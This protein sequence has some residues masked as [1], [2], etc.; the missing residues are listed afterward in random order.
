LRK[1][2]FKWEKSN[3]GPKK[4]KKGKFVVVA[5]SLNASKCTVSALRK[6]CSVAN[7]VLAKV[8]PTPN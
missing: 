6:N 4:K 5:K 2:R 1:T 7:S 3:R 8:A